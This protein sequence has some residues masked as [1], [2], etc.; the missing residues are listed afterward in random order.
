MYEK[1]INPIGYL[2]GKV[3]IDVL[4]WR[5]YPNHIPRLNADSSSGL[6]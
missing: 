1:W 3:S 6:V 2:D 4:I 5:V